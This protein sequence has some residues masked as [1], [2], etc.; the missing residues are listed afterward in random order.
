MNSANAG[1]HAR[2]TDEQA[3]RTSADLAA[4]PSITHEVLL[5]DAGRLVV[6]APHPDDEV[7]GCGGLMALARARGLEVLLISLT[8]GE[9]AYPD[10]DAWTPQVLGPFRRVELRTA[11]G[12]LGVPAEAI[13][14]LGLGDGA[15]TQR[16]DAAMQALLDHLR[17]N[18]LVMVTW[19]ADGHSDHEAAATAA[20]AAV[21]ASAQS[22]IRLLQYPIWAWHWAAP[23][24]G[25]F[26]TLDA[27]RLSLPAPAVAAK[28]AAMACL[29]SQTGD[30]TPS[31]QD[32]IL[33]AFALER[34]HRDFE[35][36]I[37]MA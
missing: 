25:P 7:L 28:R 18:D 2:G 37:A 34:F 26:S 19:Q 6:V 31:V 4:L 33:P 8:D 27:V 15:L 29:G 1:P 17:D 36:F 22:G 3:W 14:H 24:A 11:C 12:H 30:C 9:N 20:A 10:L 5:A 32:P 35:V 16:I 13:V 23:H 21:K